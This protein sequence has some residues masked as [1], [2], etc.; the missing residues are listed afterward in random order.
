MFGKYLFRLS[1]VVFEGNQI[2]EFREWK[3]VMSAIDDDRC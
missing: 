2:S 3:N 1:L